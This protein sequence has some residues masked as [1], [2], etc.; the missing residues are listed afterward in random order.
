MKERQDW[1]LTITLNSCGL[2]SIMTLGFVHLLH[3][4]NTLFAAQQ[5]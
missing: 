1:K 3:K 2:I 4:D 5:C